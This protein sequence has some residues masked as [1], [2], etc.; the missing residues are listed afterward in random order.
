MEL[1]EKIAAQIFIGYT[2]GKST[3]NDIADRI[4]TIPEI[5]EA[6]ELLTRKRESEE[7]AEETMNTVRGMNPTVRSTVGPR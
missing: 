3:L 7:Q 1:R 4:L 6:L 2:D 5:A